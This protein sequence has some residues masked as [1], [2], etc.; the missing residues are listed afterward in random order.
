MPGQG[1]QWRLYLFEPS[2]GPS[3]SPT[4]DLPALFDEA[5]TILS[6]TDPDGTRLRAFSIQAD[7]G[8]WAGRVRRDLVDAGWHVVD[9]RR[10]SLR[11][12]V[13]L[14]HSDAGPAR[15]CLLHAHTDAA[16]VVHGIVSFPGRS[17]G[18]STRGAP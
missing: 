16:G 4:F 7:L 8:Q 11:W 9:Q 18:F 2:D 1:S 10:E 14:V 12:S 3:T 6:V 13:Q 17:A 5:R 15:T